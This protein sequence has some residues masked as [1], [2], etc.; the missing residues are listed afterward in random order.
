M[1][2]DQA[3]A[4]ELYDEAH[5]AGSSAAAYFL[6]HRFHVGDEELGVEPDGVRAL[7][8]LQQASE[9]VCEDEH[10]LHL[11]PGNF[12]FAVLNVSA[13]LQSSLSSAHAHDADVVVA[14]TLV[15]SIAIVGFLLPRCRAQKDRKPMAISLSL[16]NDSLRGD[17][18]FSR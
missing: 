2:C 3:R 16:D 12:V 17:L 4:R 1:P 13:A 15:P 8:L 6:G 11:S 10:M 7:Q 5:E 18:S 9:Q 14:F